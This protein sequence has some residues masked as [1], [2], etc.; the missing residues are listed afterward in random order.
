MDERF[1]M[2][3]LSRAF[4]AVEIWLAVAYLVGMFVAATFRPGNITQGS[5]FRGSYFT[6]AC[7]LTIPAIINAIAILTSL[8]RHPGLGQGQLALVA[9]QLSEVLGRILLAASIVLALASLRGPDARS[10][11][12]ETDRL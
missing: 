10:L 4:G 2:S 3:L 5:T 11:P 1:G 12:P 8:D 6:F 7:Y 9:M